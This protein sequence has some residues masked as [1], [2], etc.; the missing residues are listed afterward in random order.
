MLFSGLVSPAHLVLIAERGRG[1]IL[2][3]T[4]AFDSSEF[5]FRHSV[6]RGEVACSSQSNSL[7]PITFRRSNVGAQW[8]VGGR[9][10]GTD[11]MGW[12]DTDLQ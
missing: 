10:N 12:D 2:F 11:G 7:S 6:A 1:D 9:D 5:F 3:P 4:A 8:F